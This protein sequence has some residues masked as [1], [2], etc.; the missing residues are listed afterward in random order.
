MAVRLRFPHLFHLLLGVGLLQGLVFAQGLNSPAP[1]AISDLK[2]AI[3]KVLGFQSE[4]LKVSG[5]DV[6]DALVGQT[7][8]YEFDIEIGNKKY[9]FKLLEDV[10]RWEYVDLPIF[11]VE[12]SAAQNGLAKTG[13][14]SDELMPV[15]AP[16]QLAGPMELWIQD[17][18]DMRVSIPH[19]VDAGVVKKVMLAEGTTV[20]VKGARSVSLRHPL[21]LPLPLNQTHKSGNLA[22][23]LLT[24]ADHLHLASLSQQ[25]P[26]L[27]LRIV[28]PTSL[29][30]P[31]SSPSKLKLKRLAPGLVELSKTSPTT[32]AIPIGAEDEHTILTPDRFT[33]L[34]PLASIN[35]SNP[36]LQGFEK[37]LY[38]VLGDKAKKAGSFRL[39][40]AEVSAQT[41]VK[42]GFRVERSIK[43]GEM[44]WSGFPEWK[45]KPET[46]KMYFEV[47]GKVEGNKVIPERV[48][49]VPDPVQV[50]D[51][52]ATN[53][54]TG[55]QT[56]STL[57]IVHPP[58]N[59]FTL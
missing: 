2:D 35:G 29:A 40:K 12:E 31:S 10:N 27:S 41:S 20:T 14:S 11:R 7:V 23:G 18:D 49:E 43:D 44:D 26:L 13:E 9:P 55:N 50:E 58:A 39:V 34:W 6:R 17:G 28:G 38:S 16:F 48:M 25:M 53:L 4:D 19:D 24:L 5:F 45:T 22:S 21:D 3:V 8:A 47:L 51:S 57:P 32:P 54:L 33:T 52:V 30:S 37:L 42:M 46:M 56:M 36:N 15:L 59:Y 1:K